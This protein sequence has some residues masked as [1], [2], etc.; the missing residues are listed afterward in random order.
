[1]NVVFGLV[2]GMAVDVRADIEA[3]LEIWVKGVEIGVS[4]GRVLSR[5]VAEVVRTAVWRTRETERE[6]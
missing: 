3:A 5:G 1:M 4:A 2:V 6:Y